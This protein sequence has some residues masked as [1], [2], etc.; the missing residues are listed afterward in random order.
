VPAWKRALATVFWLGESE[1][2]DNDHIANLMSA[3][4]ATWVEHF[5]G[6]DDPNNRCGYQP[7]GFEPKENPF[8]VALPYDDMQENGRRKEVNASI[9]WD[10]PGVNSRC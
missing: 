1:T 3:W 9:P 10:A 7:C 2:D 4:D 5:G 8:Y 6:I